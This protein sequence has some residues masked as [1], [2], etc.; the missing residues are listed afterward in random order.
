[1]KYPN[2]TIQEA[3]NNYHAGLDMTADG[4]YIGTSEQ[5]KRAEIFNNDLEE[6]FYVNEKKEMERAD[7]NLIYNS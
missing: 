5:W 4:R 2:I 6:A 3:I 1:M 7:N